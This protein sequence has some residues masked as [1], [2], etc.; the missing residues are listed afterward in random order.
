MSLPLNTASLKVKVEPLQPAESAESAESKVLEIVNLPSNIRI[1]A[2]KEKIFQEAACAEGSHWRLLHADGSK[3]SKKHV[4]HI[5]HSPAEEPQIIF[6]GVET[7]HQEDDKSSK[8]SSTAPVHL[9][10]EPIEQ[11]TSP[12]RAEA[13]SSSVD[14]AAAAQPKTTTPTPTPSSKRKKLLIGA[15]LISSLVIAYS[16]K[17]Y[18]F[19]SPKKMYPAIIE[20]QVVIIQ[21]PTNNKA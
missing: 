16:V 17:R 21:Y 20:E 1:K 8:G 9:E 6:R 3:L 19:G 11:P 10:E 15:A 13:E 18:F 12:E 14:E 4:Q 7:P 5:I 2:L